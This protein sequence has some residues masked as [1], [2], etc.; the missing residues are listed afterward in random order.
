M[1]WL[2]AVTGVLVWGWLL[3]AMGV[4]VLKHERV[5]RLLETRQLLPYTM[6][7]RYRFLGA[8][9]GM[10]ARLRLPSAVRD[11]EIIDAHNAIT[12]A[13]MQQLRDVYVELDAL[14]PF[15]GSPRRTPT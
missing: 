5:R 14:P 10:L 9:G 1:I 2:F 4:A 11:R 13:D 8:L 6:L 15:T 7:A 12:L 3:L